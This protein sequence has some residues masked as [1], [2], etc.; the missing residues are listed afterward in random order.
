MSSEQVQTLFR[1]NR[2]TLTPFNV[3]IQIISAG[4]STP[5]VHWQWEIK[6]FITFISSHIYTYLVTHVVPSAY[7]LSAIVLRRDPT[8]DKSAAVSRL[9]GAR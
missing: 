9:R 7:Q 3:Q 8:F 6:I 4:Y 2:D 5:S 1:N